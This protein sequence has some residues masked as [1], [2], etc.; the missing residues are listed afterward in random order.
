MTRN[1]VQSQSAERAS[2]TETATDTL[3]DLS[4]NGSVEPPPVIRTECGWHELLLP[5]HLATTLM[6]SMGVALFAFN[7]FFVSTVLPSAIAEIGGGHLIAW[8]VSLYLIGSIVAGVTA[9][10]LKQRFGARRV[11]VVA[12]LVFLGG[13]LTAALADTMEQVLLGRVGQG[14]GEGVVAAICYALIPALYPSR[15]VPKVFGVEAIVWT[16]A[17]FG[18]P[19]ASGWLAESF[20]WRTAFL[21]N[22][23]LGLVFLLLALITARTR[24]SLGEQA[25]VPI[26]P[27][28]MLAVGL[29]MILSSGVAQG[30]WLSAMLLVFGLALLGLSVRQDRR[31]RSSLMPHTAFG[32]TSTVGAGLW[33]VLLMPVAQATSGVYFVFGLQ[34]G[35]GFGPL[36]AGGLGAIMAM[37]WSLVAVLIA[38]VGTA[39]A[40]RRAIEA[41]PVLQFAGMVIVAAGFHWS[42]LPLLVAG[43][44]VVGA[45]FGASWAFLSQMLMEASVPGERD[46]T[47]GLIPTLQSAGFAIGAAFAGL[48]GNSLGLAEATAS[49][50]SRVAFSTTFLIPVL[51]TIP[52]MLLARR[53]TRLAAERPHSPQY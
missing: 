42:T 27:L 44:I 51:W 4:E 39:G 7:S 20:S 22:L 49:D 37:S 45:A 12:T 24:E 1:R 33:L 53:A 52:A 40:R 31:S 13:T 38:H 17:S 21:I 6:L 32:L 23:P 46:K 34:R 26:A 3:V 5:A 43:Q 8:S 15:L 25:P 48:A 9:A 14:L 47:S 11:L 41:G 29:L 16:C 35:F 28:V 19:F 30:V 18:G 10:R 2:M 50:T 36:A